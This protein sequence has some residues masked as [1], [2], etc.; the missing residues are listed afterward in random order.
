MKK[1]LLK[2]DEPNLSPAQDDCLYRCSYKFKEAYEF[3]R[4]TLIF[5]KKFIFI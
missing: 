2:F 4:D 3:G 5:Q 1:C